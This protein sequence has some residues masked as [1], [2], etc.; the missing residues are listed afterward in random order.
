MLW[1]IKV[2]VLPRDQCVRHSNNDDDNSN[3]NSNNNNNN[4]VVL[5][6]MRI[7]ECHQFIPSGSSLKK[8]DDQELRN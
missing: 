4:K 8:L 3:S 5:L 7:L 1:E 2:T 6:S